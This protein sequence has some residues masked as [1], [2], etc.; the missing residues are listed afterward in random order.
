M[1]ESSSGREQTKAGKDESGSPRVREQ[2]KENHAEARD[3]NF[4]EGSERLHRPL[5]A[6]TR[7]HAPA[8]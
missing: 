2:S 1:C 4:Y 3:D 6:R 5:E 7:V 8:R